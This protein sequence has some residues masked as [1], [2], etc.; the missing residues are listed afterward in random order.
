MG[1]SG[2]GKSTLIRM[3]N[4]LISPTVGEIL[5]DNED[6]VKMNAPR[7]REVR[8]KKISMVFQNF[9][10]FPH[11]TILENTEFGL[12]IQKMPAEQRREKAMDALKVVGLEDMNTNC[13][14]N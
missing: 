1:L 6:I 14:L 2:S 13:P 4:R 3:F 7:L 8:Q 11:K 5:I 10:L 9:A 12:E